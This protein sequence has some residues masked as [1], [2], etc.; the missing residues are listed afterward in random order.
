MRSLIFTLF[1]FCLITP[2]QAQQQEW[3][4]TIGGTDHDVPTQLITDSQGNV[5]NFGYFNETVDFDPGPEVFELTSSSFSDPYLLKLD[6][7]GDFVWAR[8]FPFVQDFSSEE[9]DIKIDEDD[10]IT[11]VIT[12][13]NTL[14]LD[15]GTPP[16]QAVGQNDFAIA[17]FDPDGNLLW[18]YS[19]GSSGREYA[20]HILNTQNNETLILGW[21]DSSLDFNPQG[22]PEV[23][24]PIGDIDFYIL[25]LDNDG[26][27]IWVKQLGTSNG[28]ISGLA[29]AERNNL[30]SISGHFNGTVDFD[31]GTSSFILDGGEFDDGFTLKL[32]ADGEFVWA[33]QFENEAIA[34]L[35]IWDTA[36]DYEE[37][38][39][40]S[41]RM[42]EPIDFNPGPSSFIIDPINVDGFVVKLSPNG[43]FLWAK[44]FG[45]P[46]AWYNSVRSMAIDSNN[47]L[48]ATGKFLSETDFDPDPG[49]SFVLTSHGKK[50]SF[51]L[52]LS[53]DGSFLHASHIGGPEWDVG[54]TIHINESDYIYL[55][56]TFRE[57]ADL[58]FG[59][60]I[61]NVTAIGDSD[62]FLT[63]ILTTTLGTRSI[64]NSPIASVYPNP[65]QGHITL[66]LNESYQ[67]VEVKIFNTL[68]Q[69]VA[70]QKKLQT[71]KLKLQM[72][73]I[74][75]IYLAQIWVD[76]K[77]SATV[78]ILKE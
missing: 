22:N 27:F 73:Q 24:S 18:H 44:N 76:G 61:T 39:Y 37:N 5:Y 42:H 21:F 20:T 78:R 23:L 2:L 15:P 40:I 62:I 33:T 70:V 30:L 49:T 64:N 19:I 47:D 34:A 4:K 66:Q 72:P 11:V 29:L 68:G 77:E 32:D 59:E 46:D 16:L 69:L 75:G 51:L 17:K 14:E 8:S 50:D 28:T 60:G 13:Y 43:D 67:T 12:Y 3:I 53:E 36:I 74:M 57:T 54:T 1:F 9:F 45:G 48:I 7:E 6:A 25:K 65:T 26:N 71:D 31:P 52:K 10:N 55:G 58:Q 35:R 63:K 41:G 56:S 38:V